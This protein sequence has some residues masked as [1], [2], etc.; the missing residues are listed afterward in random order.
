VQG[1]KLRGK[2]AYD[3][4]SHTLPGGFRERIAPGA[5]AKASKARLVA[6]VNHDPSRL[7]GRYPTTLTVEE[8][9]D[10][11]AWEVA[12]PSG[13]TG[14]DVLIGAERGD[15]DGTSF[16]FVVG[17]DRWE[18]DVRVVEEIAELI[19]LSVV[20]HPAYPGTGIELRSTDPTDPK[21]G[22]S[23][24]T[25]TGG[26]GLAV[27]DRTVQPGGA[28]EGLHAR[29][30]RA[31][32]EPSTR[33]EIPWPE[34]LGATEQRALT[35]AGDVEDVSMVR[36]DG[37][38][39]GVDRR[40]AWPAFASVGVDAGTTSVQVLRQTARTLADPAD[41]IRAIDATHDKAEA[42]S[43]VS[44]ATLP[45]LQ[46]AAIQA[47]IPNIYLEQNA[48]RTVI[49]QD[50]RL[51]INEALDKLVLDALATADNYDPD[52]DELLIA[53]R[54]AIT[55]NQAAGYA[56]DTLILTPGESEALDVLQTTGPE[57]A[58]VFGAGRFAPGELFGLRT[59]V[60]KSAA[61]AIVVDASAFGRMYVS[62]IGLQR[63]EENDGRTNT[64]LLRMEGNAAFGIERPDAAVRVAES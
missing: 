20:T 23:M 22:R 35:W 28:G 25:D 36:R 30:V 51:S 14:Q 55:I 41:V 43:D 4:L 62:P 3:V 39:L 42:D 50:L 38:A 2:V 7:L 60:S 49:G 34:F 10:G 32:W 13:P 45:M 54:K 33:A 53:I 44:V 47:Q 27:E 21:E 6:T 12:L 26:G 8:R 56:P 31:G 18:G 5:F 29:F 63:F 9:S 58:Y 16:R 57:G 59:R 17:R 11:L 15:W 1:R 46:V 52:G 61:S 37:V 19:D 48:I 24:E 40:W 64:S